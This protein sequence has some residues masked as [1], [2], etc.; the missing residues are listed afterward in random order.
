MNLPADPG[1]LRGVGLLGKVY[2]PVGKT[3]IIY[4]ILRDTT[5]NFQLPH[6]LSWPAITGCRGSLFLISGYN[7]PQFTLTNAGWCFLNMR[8]W[9]QIMPIPTPRARACCVSHNGNVYVI[10]G[11]NQGILNTVESYDP[12]TNC[13]SVRQPMPVAV[14]EAACAVYRQHIYVI[15]GLHEVQRRVGVVQRYN[16]VTNTWTLLETT[17][18]CPR[19]ELSAVVF[20]DKLY[21]MCGDDGR[22]RVKVVES[23]D[24]VTWKIEQ[25]VH[26][27]VFRVVDVCNV[28]E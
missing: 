14:C 18:S 15:G 22:Q 12:L 16:P 2:I 8:E 25:N 19:D 21:V 26:D 1:A 17:I 24:G 23:F 7:V 10:G 28:N 27:L 13:W 11:S 3:G 9:Q 20:R 6:Y 5:S 4:D